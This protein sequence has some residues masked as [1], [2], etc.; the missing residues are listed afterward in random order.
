[1]ITA[2]YGGPFFGGG[3]FGSPA[4]GGGGVDPDPSGG[5]FKPTGLVDRP[6]K[7]AKTS[8]DRR[9]EETREIHAEVSAKLARELHDTPD[10]QPP[11]V[12]MTLAEVDA[13]IGTLLRKVQRTQEEE[14]LLLMLMA[15]V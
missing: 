10:I 6:P 2:F 7:A 5:I 13:E 12:T 15:V 4:S 11:I 1:V 14:A 8:V 9:V 3:F